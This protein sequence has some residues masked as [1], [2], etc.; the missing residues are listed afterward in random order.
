MYFTSICPCQSATYWCMLTLEE[1]QAWPVSSGQLT[2]FNVGTI[3]Q[4]DGVWHGAGSASMLD[5]FGETGHHSVRQ[6]IRGLVPL[7]RAAVQPS[8]DGHAMGGQSCHHHPWQRQN[9]YDRQL[10]HSLGWPR[11]IYWLLF[12]VFPRQS[13]LSERTISGS[14]KNPK[15][16]NRS[17]FTERT[18]CW[19]KV[20]EDLKGRTAVRSGEK[21]FLEK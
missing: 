8:T 13:A 12:S 10:D 17:C 18:L 15:V 14:F 19:Y 16:Q 9:S 7:A 20:I 21:A 6:P 1:T 3:V 5:Y 2:G 11:Y 4:L